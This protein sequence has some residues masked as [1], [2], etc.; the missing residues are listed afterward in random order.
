MA[1]PLSL[2][3]LPSAGALWILVNMHTSLL[4]RHSIAIKSALVL[5]WMSPLFSF[6]VF[7]FRSCGMPFLFGLTVPQQQICFF[8]KSSNNSGE[9]KKLSMYNLWPCPSIF[10]VNSVTVAWVAVVLCCALSVLPQVYVHVIR[11]SS[12]V[13]KIENFDAET[14]A[15]FLVCTVWKSPSLWMEQ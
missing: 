3:K 10:L 11:V 8:T 7:G 9:E 15:F 12:R 14:L 13:T 1:F 5:T 6:A 2:Q 4:S